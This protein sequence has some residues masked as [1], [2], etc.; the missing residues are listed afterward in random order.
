MPAGAP[1]PVRR[2]PVAAPKAPKAAVAG[3]GCGPFLAQW[4]TRPTVVEYAKSGRST[5]KACHLPID[6]GEV[7]IGTE[8][9]G[10]TAYGG[11][12][13]MTSW[14][15]VGCQPRSRNGGNT[16]Y[17]KAALR[18][19]DRAYVDAWA[20]GDRSAMDAHLAR[21][22]ARRAAAEESGGRRGASWVVSGSCG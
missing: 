19:G 7:R 2:A 1:A 14:K 9:L 3:G 20:R 5:C 18:S 12:F 11:E 22:R 13:M 16:L 15:H 10:E 4:E 8:G 6:K 21:A 17:G